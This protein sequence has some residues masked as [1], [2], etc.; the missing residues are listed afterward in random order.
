MPDTCQ[1]PTALRVRPSSAHRAV[2]SG[3]LLTALVML[4][5]TSAADAQF[6]VC[7]QTL[8]VVNVAIGQESDA[9]GGTGA[10]DFVTEGWW[11][12]GAN[13]CANV[14]QDVLAKRYIYVYATDIFGRGL[15]NG[16][17]TMCVDRRRFRIPGIGRCWERG[18]VEASFFEVDTLDQPR[19]TLFLTGSAP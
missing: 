17:T 2:A 11:T 19:W 6:T 12:V 10:P 5:W 16:L 4:L 18:L 1:L 8:D 14:I 13:Q 7:N 3:C 15:L 9:S